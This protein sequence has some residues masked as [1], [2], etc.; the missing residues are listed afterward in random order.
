MSEYTLP[1]N[2]FVSCNTVDIKAAHA[3]TI[4]SGCFNAETAP[5][6]Q[7]GE[8]IAMGTCAIVNC[9]ACSENSAASAP[10]IPEPCYVSENISKPDPRVVANVLRYLTMCSAE[11]EKSVDAASAIDG[12]KAENENLK[13][14][15]DEL[16][17]ENN[18]LKAELESLRIKHAELENNHA[19][20][21]NGFNSVNMLIAQLSK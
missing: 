4:P 8:G 9:K 1:P 12:F 2:I 20:I 10:A 13:K 21:V 16:A 19:I 17:A 5:V 14:Q 6:H 7:P 3:D 18:N 15:V 11:Y